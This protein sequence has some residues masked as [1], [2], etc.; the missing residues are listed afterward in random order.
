MIYDSNRITTKQIDTYM[1]NTHLNHLAFKPTYEENN[2]VS[3]LDLRL[4][5]HNTSVITNI[6]R[7]PTT[8]DTT[9]HYTSNHPLEQKLAA[10][11]FL[12]SRM[13]KL[14]LTQE[15]RKQENNIMRHIAK[16]NGYPVK[17]I[18]KLQ[19]KIV[20]KDDN[21]TQ[22]NQQPHNNATAHHSNWYLLLSRLS[23]DRDNCSQ[24][25]IRGRS[26]HSPLSNSFNNLHL[27]LMIYLNG[28]TL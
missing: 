18:D 9:I 22:N 14:P 26:L 3:Y 21:I 4:S 11:R 23:S 20:T 17:L 1:N 27:T 24:G 5:R 28:Y 8:T 25:N 15:A 7:K 13:Q 19:H 16:N 2:T 12:E 6:F 10:F